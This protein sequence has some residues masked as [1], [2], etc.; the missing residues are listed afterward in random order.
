MRTNLD[1]T[2]LFRSS[3][4]FDRI[5][6]MLENAS[7]V[8]AIDNWP[9]YDIAKAGE[10]AYRITMAVA[11]FS[12]E[13]LTITHQPNLLV[14]SGSQSSDDDGQYLYRGIA[15]R[16]FERR[17][18]LADH[19]QVVGASLDNGLLNID[20]KREL[21]EEMK[22]RR[23]ALAGSPAKAAPRQIDAEKNAA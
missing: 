3:I 11:G 23:I 22:P 10:D 1:F 20:L 19:V 2:P 12:Q 18:E 8:T 13:Q 15:G 21:P 17:F 16:A 7:R 4:G 14:V 9:P 6:N 5:L